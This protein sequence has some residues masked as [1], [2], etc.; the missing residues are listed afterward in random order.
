MANSSIYNSL[1]GGQRG[2]LKSVK[3]LVALMNEKKQF[4]ILVF[5][6]LIVQLGITY[7]IMVKT[8]LNINWLPLFIANMILIFVLALVPMP[9]FVKFILFC[10]FSAIFGVMLSALKKKYNSATIN[11]AIQGA[12]AVFGVCLAA[13]VA[14]LLGGIRL[15]YKFGAFLFWALLALIVGELVFISSSQVNKIF[16]F[17]GILLFAVY[18]VYDTN[19]ILQRD[20]SG[21]F[22]TA[23]LDY[24]LDILNLF[25][26]LLGYNSN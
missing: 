17:I 26:N 10:I 15:G 6:N 8:N 2:G 21:D 7:Y 16:S 4:F 3:N 1:F 14:L 11:I 24:Y 19:T 22:I 12:L 20:Y 18:V 25:T 13:G 23:S 5:A 9:Q